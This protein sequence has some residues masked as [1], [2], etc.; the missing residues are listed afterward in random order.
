MR[1]LISLIVVTVLG[2]AGLS[3]LTITAGTIT[4][5]VNYFPI[6]TFYSYN[7]TQQ[8]Y[9]QSQINYQGEISKIRFHRSG[10]G[11]AF[12]CSHDW[13]IYMGHTGRNSFSSTSDWEPVGNLTQVFSGSV[14][15]NFPG[16]GQWMEITLDTPTLTTT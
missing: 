11:G 5:T 15:S 8:I 9:T 14:L 2:L 10:T 6:Y 1:R 16:A 13:V 4:E 12:D 7:Y 3:A